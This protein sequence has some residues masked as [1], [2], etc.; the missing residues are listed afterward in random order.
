MVWLGLVAWH[1][2][3]VRRGMGLV[4]RVGLNGGGLAW[5]GLV[6]RGVILVRWRV[7]A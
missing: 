7:L 1:G 2:V 5:H 3:V 6:W 4:H